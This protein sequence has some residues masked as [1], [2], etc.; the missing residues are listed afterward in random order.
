MASLTVRQR[1]PVFAAIDTQVDA[2]PGQM[3]DERIEHPCRRV[4]RL[5]PSLVTDTGEGAAA[6]GPLA[7]LRRR[8][9]QGHPAG[10]QGVQRNPHL[11]HDV[12]RLRLLHA[13]GIAILLAA[14]R[15]DAAGPTVQVVHVTAPSLDRA[16]TAT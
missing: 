11:I 9:T 15:A 10:V 14:H 12:E 1:P 5:G 4:A 16:G 6:L 3:A 2:H 8:L 7:S 13:T